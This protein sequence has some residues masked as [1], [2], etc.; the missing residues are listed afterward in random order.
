MMF[1]ITIVTFRMAFLM[2]KWTN[3]VMDYGWVEFIHWPKPYL[4]LSATCDEIL[5][6]MIEMW[7]R[8]Y[9]VS[10]SY[11]NIVNPQKELQGMRS[12]VGLVFT[13]ATSHT[14]QGAW[15]WNCESPKEVSKGHP[16]H[17]Q[18]HVVWSRILKY[19][20]K[21]YVTVLSTKCYF[22][23]FLFMCHHTW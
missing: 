9:L 23:E 1:Y 14:S 17:L 20:A 21:G 10:D 5:S 2:K 19:S 15:P 12:I 13:R 16:K 6:W 4:S 3:I 22:N 18:N 8:D 11:C 7:M